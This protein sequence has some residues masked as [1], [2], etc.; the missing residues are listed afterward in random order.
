MPYLPSHCLNS[1]AVVASCIS[2]GYM[3]GKCIPNHLSLRSPVA[4]AET[5]IC[6]LD[7]KVLER[8]QTWLYEQQVST[9]KVPSPCRLSHPKW[10]HSLHNPQFTQS[11][12]ALL[13]IHK[14]TCEI[15]LKWQRMPPD[16]LEW[17]QN[18]EPVANQATLAIDVVM[19]KFV[20]QQVCFIMPFQCVSNT[21][22]VKG[23]HD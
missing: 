1:R 5:S 17:I 13:Q 12:R 23:M 14:G 2:Q 22:N 21:L 19:C 18:L 4:T 7:F 15:L 9:L 10:A 11:P 16:V 6:K 20:F 8:K 3:G